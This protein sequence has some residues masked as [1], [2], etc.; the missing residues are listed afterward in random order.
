[1]QKKIKVCLSLPYPQSSVDFMTG[2]HGSEIPG[3]LPKVMVAYLTYKHLSKESLIEFCQERSLTFRK[4]K[5]AQLITLLEQNNQAQN[6][7]PIPEPITGLLP[8]LPV[9]KGNVSGGHHSTWDGRW[10]S[11]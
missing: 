10:E 8:N 2:G 3:C 7:E 6:P 9:H 1:M 11:P 5:K 4:A